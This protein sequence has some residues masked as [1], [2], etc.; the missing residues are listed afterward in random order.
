MASNPGGSGPVL[1]I[2]R[3]DVR[4]N[5]WDELKA[6]IRAVVG[7]VDRHPPQMVTYGF[8][9][10]VRGTLGRANAPV[11]RSPFLDNYDETRCPTRKARTTS[12][13]CCGSSTL[14][15]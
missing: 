2:D 14:Q 15:R 8:Y 5:Y 6:G 12:L 7:F 10:R 4:E 11:E 3:S 9:Q 1:D 13:N